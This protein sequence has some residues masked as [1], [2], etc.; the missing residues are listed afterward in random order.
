MKKALED[1]RADGQLDDNRELF[2]GANCM[3][4]QLPRDYI[5]EL[6]EPLKIKENYTV[7][8]NKLYAGCKS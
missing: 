8:V 2:S 1:A 3:S 7:Q 6:E 5:V 4:P